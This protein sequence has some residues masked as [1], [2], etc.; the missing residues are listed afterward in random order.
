[1]S[2]LVRLAQTAATP[3]APQAVTAPVAGAQPT[4]YFSQAG[5]LP[6]QY[7]GSAEQNEKLRQAIDKIHGTQS[8]TFYD[9]YV[10]NIGKGKWAQHPS[11]RITKLNGGLPTVA[12]GT[13]NGAPTA[14]NPN[15]P[16]ASGQ[17]NP[18]PKGFQKSQSGIIIPPL[19]R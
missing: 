14:N 7:V 2:K 19:P 4:N 9:A 1:M 17:V 16:A 3:N 5:I 11:E 10:N 8:R 15:T 13:I 18:L 12:N 6:S